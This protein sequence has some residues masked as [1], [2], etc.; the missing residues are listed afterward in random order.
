MILVWS[1]SLARQDASLVDRV[2][3]IVFVI[4]AWIYWAG[5]SGEWGWPHLAAPVLVTIWGVRL[6]W[7]LTRRNWGKGEDF[8]YRAMRETHGA[9][10][11]WV[12]LFTVFLLQGAL[13]W[14]IAFPLYA[15]ASPRSHLGWLVWVG[16]AVWLV[17]F[18][19]EAVGDHQLARFKAD[20]GNRGKVLD[21]GLWR[22][23]RHPNYFGDAVVWWGYWLI[24]VAAGGW[25][26]AFGPLL[27]T[28]LLM[29]VSGVTLLEK[30]LVETRPAYRSYTERTSAFFPLPR[31]KS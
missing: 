29:R 17:G 28:I 19:F 20:P 14:L 31:S 25:W 5:Q 6:S 18:L 21:T 24:A 15:A 27:M 7:H 26:T 1:A 11:G 10:F 8:R 23:T 4:L 13:A 16:T 12:S 22:Y 2:W 30:T 9:R 3:G